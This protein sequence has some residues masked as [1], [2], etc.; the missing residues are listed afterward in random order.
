MLSLELMLI[1]MT[2]V[3]P[4][5]TIN[6]TSFAVSVCCLCLIIPV[7]FANRA[8]SSTNSKS[9]SRTCGC[10]CDLMIDV[11]KPVLLNCYLLKPIP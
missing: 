10:R 7:E 1:I 3:L 6:P 11:M 2:S 9:L 8:M 4:V 5:L